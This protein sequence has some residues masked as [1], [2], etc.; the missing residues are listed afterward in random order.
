MYTIS[1][2]GF[3]TR[4]LATGDSSSARLVNGRFHPAESSGRLLERTFLRK[5]RRAHCPVLEKT[6]S[7]FAFPYNG[8]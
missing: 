4:F 2:A 3:Q 8:S 5:P 7:P 1:P 6:L